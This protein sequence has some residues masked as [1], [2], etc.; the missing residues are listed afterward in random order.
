[1]TENKTGEFL[2]LVADAVRTE[3]LRKLIFSRPVSGDAEKITGR[4]VAH[5]G[6]RML[7]LEY[8]LRDTV[9]QENIPEGGDR[10]GASRPDL[11]VFA[12]QSS[13]GARRRGIQVRKARRGVARCGKTAAQVCRRGAGLCLVR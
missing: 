8:A 3:S 12:G 10:N 13:D 2:A 6:R 9:R 11:P 4:L 7:A 1:M 5:R